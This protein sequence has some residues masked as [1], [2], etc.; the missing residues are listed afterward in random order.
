[1]IQPS[2]VVAV[3]AGSE[4]LLVLHAGTN[5]TEAEQVYESAR[6]DEKYSTVALC[7]NVHPRLTSHPALDA[8]SRRN[9]ARNKQLAAAARKD[10]AEREIFERIKKAEKELEKAQE[11]FEAL[12]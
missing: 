10:E 12:Q 5:A 8:E 7:Q 1:M 9:E 4:T 11:D 6:L 3:E 2:I